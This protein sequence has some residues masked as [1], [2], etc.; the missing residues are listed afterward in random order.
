MTAEK[1]ISAA[2]GEIGVKESP[3]GSNSVKYN[4]SYYGRRV[5]G[6]AYPWC[7]VFVWWVFNSS[8]AKEL[9]YGGGK[10]AYCPEAERYYK[11]KGQWETRG[12]KG[13]IVFFDFSKKGISE[14]MGIVENVNGD[15]TITSI[16]GNTSVTS[17]DN[18][19]T[20]MRRIRS[21][22]YVRGY[23]RPEYSEHLG[24]E[25]AENM[26]ADGIITKENLDNWKMFLSGDYPCPIQ[27]VR[28]VLDRYH[29][30]LKG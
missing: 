9:F 14:H 7:C 12:K 27:Y 19:G 13:D 15:G 18:G 4:D 29:E 6:S 2:A 23:A 16:E 22:S 1:I 28:T 21:L 25:T 17:N 30:K 11:A 8:G 20:V 3:A 10:T 24:K 26:L 5:S